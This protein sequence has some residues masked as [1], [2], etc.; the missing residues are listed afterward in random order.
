MAYESPNT[1]P[2]NDED[3]NAIVKAM[4]ITSDGTESSNVIETA[5]D[6]RTIFNNSGAITPPYDPTTLAFLY[7]MSGALRSN[8]DAYVTN[9]ESFGHTFEPVIDLDSEAAFEEVK[10]AL[11]EERLIAAQRGPDTQPGTDDDR[12]EIDPDADE[13]PEPT[14]AEIN[15][16]IKEI[17][18]QLVREKGRAEK[19]FEYCSVDEPFT[20]LRAKTRQDVEVLGYGFWEVLRNRNGDVSQ[21]V[22]IPAFTMRLMPRDEQAVETQTPIMST[23]VTQE[24]RIMKRRFRKFLQVI[25]AAQAKVWFKELGDPRVYS[26]KTGVQYNDVE[27]LA[28]AEPDTPPATEVIYFKI[29]SSRTPYGIPRWIS[30]LVSVLG[31]RH[32][33]EVNM[34]FFEDRSIPPMVVTVSGG[35]I[36]KQEFEKIKTAWKEGVKGKRNFHKVMFIQAESNVTTPGGGRVRIDVKPLSHAAQND[37]QFLNY[38]ERNTDLIG[39]VFRMPRLLRGDARDFNRATA[40]TSLEFTEQQVFGPLRKEFDFLINRRILAEL[41]ICY[42]RFKSKGPDFG[43]PYDLIKTLNEAVKAGWITIG[44][45]RA[46]GGPAFNQDFKVIDEEWAEVPVPLLLAG[47][48]LETELEAPP[49]GEA[50]PPSGEDE[51]TEASEA[52]EDE[53]DEE[54]PPVDVTPARQRKRKSARRLA[55]QAERLIKLRR[56]MLRRAESS[57]RDVFLDAHA[58]INV[59]EEA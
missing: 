19:F 14:S 39:S 35:H 54:A 47:I 31:S 1:P 5:E 10:Q 8:V 22:Y 12:E 40:E 37:A 58:R 44:E 36:A 53:E 28:T 9:I 27:A 6:V 42:W 50:P 56:L 11:I 21:F 32:A 52:T 3:V 24:Q 4:F 55:M 18:R 30:E 49:E 43:N 48:G 34:M 46:I 51:E 17:E 15:A 59:T 38:L 13:V 7:E 26:S 2:E 29:H 23:L 20:L 16:K 57:E 25:D 45:A 41:G 33:Q